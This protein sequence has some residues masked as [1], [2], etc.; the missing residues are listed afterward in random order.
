MSDYTWGISYADG[1]GASGVCGTDTVTVGKTTVKKQCIELANKIS[2]TFV[3]DASDG[4]V[5][6]AFSSIN[7]VQP[8]P[9]STFFD[10]AKDDLDSPLFAAYLPNNAD[11]EYDFGYIDASKHS[12]TIEYAS[13]DDSNGFWEYPS[14]SYKI[15]STVHSQSGYTGISDTGTSIILMG[16]SAVDAY[17][18]KVEGASYSSSQG[19]YVFPCSATLP[20]LSF[21][22]G[23]IYYGM[24]F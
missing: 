24:Y 5:G 9:Q 7:T 23:P 15:D 4:L 12:G 19:G 17:Y 21:K 6:L 2:S 13:V 14:T 1:S 8:Q 3:S 10:N 18:A 16:D 22:V 20:S 11:G